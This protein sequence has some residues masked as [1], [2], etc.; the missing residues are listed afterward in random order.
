MREYELSTFGDSLTDGDSL[1]CTAPS[2]E[3]EASEF[4]ARFAEGGAALELGVGYG[5]VAVPLAERG[6]RVVGIETSRSMADLLRRHDAGGQVEIVLGNFADVPV[7][8]QF[9]LIY[10]VFNTF[11]C[12]LSQDEQVRCFVNV[13][14]RLKPGGVFVLQTY[15]PDPAHVAQSQFIKTT[16]VEVG[17]V[18]LLASTHDRA[19]Q[20]ISQQQIVVTGEGTKL[21]PAMFR[22]VWP[23]EL[24]LMARIA[25]LS[26][27]ERWAGWS[28]EPYTAAVG[29]YV[30]VFRRDR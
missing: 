21:Y 3:G 25:G 23:S 30:S 19:N 22:Y 6:V 9:E 4:L 12:L 11:F 16:Q 29:D 2:D 20:V 10:C 17:G 14:D 1:P 7:G 18:G 26:L 13:A 8:E 28:R 15:V 24:D 5:R 27:A